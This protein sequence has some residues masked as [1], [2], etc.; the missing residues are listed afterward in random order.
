VAAFLG[1]RVGVS[2]EVVGAEVT[3]R[4]VRVLQQVPDDDEDGASD[5][6]DGPVFAPPPGDPSVA[7][8]QEGIG[9][10][11]PDGGFAQDEYLKL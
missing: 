7:F 1:V 11:D 4:G 9:S 2:A 10:A 8:A 5:G 6:D 3:E